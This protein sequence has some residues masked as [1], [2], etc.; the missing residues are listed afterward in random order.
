ML[1]SILAFI[2]GFSFEF[3]WCKVTKAVQAREAA[4]A[5]HMSV[6]LYLCTFI[7]TMMIAHSCFWSCLTFAAGSWAGVYCGVKNER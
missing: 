7:S 6:L 2:S 3:L 5:A 1:L 4:F